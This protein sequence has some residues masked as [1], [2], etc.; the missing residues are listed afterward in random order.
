MGGQSRGCWDRGEGGGPSKNR[1]RA[2]K[3]LH[4]DTGRA[5]RAQ[6]RKAFF[7]S[8]LRFHR[9][10]LPNSSGGISK[11]RRK[12]S[13]ER[14][15]CGGGEEGDGV[16]HSVPSALPKPRFSPYLQPGPV[17]TGRQLHTAA[18][19]HHQ[20]FIGVDLQGG[21]REVVKPSPQ[22]PQSLPWPPP[23]RSPFA[24]TCWAGSCLCPCARAGRS[25]GHKC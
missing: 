21:V 4:G 1:L 3:R 24:P 12:S 11:T 7:F 8:S 15:R 6:K 20:H 19:R 14:C 23:D 18:V 10:S 2:L 9:A 17:H 16:P 22:P 25:G 5:R 13:G